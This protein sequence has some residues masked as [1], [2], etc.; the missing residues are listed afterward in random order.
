MSTLLNRRTVFA[1]IASALV[2]S[3]SLSVSGCI[4]QDV[5]FRTDDAIVV[6][7]I[8]VFVPLMTVFEC[9]RAF[10]SSGQNPSIVKDTFADV[11][12]FV[13][14]VCY[15]GVNL[16]KNVLSTGHTEDEKLRC[17][18]HSP[19]SLQRPVQSHVHRRLCGLHMQNSA[20]DLPFGTFR[21]PDR[22]WKQ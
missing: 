15:N 8:N 17:H 12:R 20:C 4:M 21:F 1:D 9:L 13:S 14:G 3:V 19:P 10:V 6:F 16:R 5:V 2:L 22:L 11:W 7:V 18:E